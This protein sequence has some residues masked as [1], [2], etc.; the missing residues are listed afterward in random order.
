MTHKLIPSPGVSKI[1]GYFLNR[2]YPS[3]NAEMYFQSRVQMMRVC[4]AKKTARGYLESLLSFAKLTGVHSKPAPSLS[5]AG[6]FVFRDSINT[7][8]FHGQ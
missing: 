6:L 2:F 7:F 8:C 5:A 1:L 4:E 3:Q